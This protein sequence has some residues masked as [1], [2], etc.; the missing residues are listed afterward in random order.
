MNIEADI[1][2]L[3]ES[4]WSLTGDLD[5]SQI[6]FQ[7]GFWRS[8]TDKYAPYIVARLVDGV[9]EQE[10]DDYFN[11]TVEVNVIIVPRS[12]GAVEDCE[13][14]A[15]TIADE[16]KRIVDG[17]HAGSISAPSGW[18]DCWLMRFAVNDVEEQDPPMLVKSLF[19]NVKYFWSTL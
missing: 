7:S 9:R 19:I 18:H 2:A 11:A 17:V 13:S 15:W 5:D 3:L 14:S 8:G 10:T 16:I 6:V 12:R 4:N 1:L